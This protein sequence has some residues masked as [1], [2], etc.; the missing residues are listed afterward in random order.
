MEPKQKSNENAMLAFIDEIH[1]QTENM[2]KAGPGPYGIGVRNQNPSGIGV[3]IS[4]E[5]PPVKDHVVFPED[6]PAYEVSVQAFS[7]E[8]RRMLEAREVEALAEDE[9]PDT[10]KIARAVTG[11]AKEARHVTREECLEAFDVLARQDLGIREEPEEP[12][13]PRR[14][15]QGPVLC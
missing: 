6:I 7:K 3:V 9:N 8:E 13:E 2:C 1:Q 12:E 11:L 5:P 10:G 4:F 14:K 15:M